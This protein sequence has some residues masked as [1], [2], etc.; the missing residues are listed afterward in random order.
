ML[1]RSLGDNSFDKEKCRSFITQKKRE[2]TEFEYEEIL[3][4]GF[5]WG[6]DICN[7]A[8]PFN[9]NPK[10]TPIKKMYENI[11]PIITEENVNI[12]IK[13]KAF[14]YRGIKTI[15]RNISIIKGKE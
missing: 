13:N 3:K 15:S 12:H 6:C 10:L 4:G 5:V 7:D 2:L 8:C 11:V 1:F 14:E 9:K